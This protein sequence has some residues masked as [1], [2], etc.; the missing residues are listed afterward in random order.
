MDEDYLDD[1]ANEVEPGEV[2]PN[3]QC[4]EELV[5]DEDDDA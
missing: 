3:C 2:H 5:D 1:E 4:F